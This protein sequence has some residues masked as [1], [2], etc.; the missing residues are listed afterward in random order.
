MPIRRGCSVPLAEKLPGVDVKVVTDV[1]AKRTAAEM[2]KELVPALAAAKSALMVWQ[3]G[4]ADAIQAVDPGSFQ[5]GPRSKGINI[6]R[7]AGR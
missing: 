3:T 4:T 1:K 6:A 7:S 2:V 5:P